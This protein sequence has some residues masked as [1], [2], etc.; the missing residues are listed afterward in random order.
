MLL[1]SPVTCQLCVGREFRVTGLSRTSVI[2]RMSELLEASYRSGDLGNQT[3]VL[4]ECVYILLSQQTRERVY[5]AVFASLKRRYPQWGDLLKAR[6]PAL[7]RLLTPAGFQRRRAEQLSQLIRRAAD[8]QRELAPSTIRDGNVNLEFLRGRSA[9]DAEKILASLPGIGPKSAR[10]VMLYALGHKVFPVDTN[11]HRMFARI[12]LVTLRGRKLDHDQLQRLVPPKLRMGLHV[13]LIHHARAVCQPQQ[14]RCSDCVLVSFCKTGQQRTRAGPRLAVDLF[15]GAGGL[16]SGF[17][18][19]GYEVVAAIEADRSAAQTYRLNNPGVAVIEACIGPH[20]T[21]DRLRRIIP[22][23]GNARFVLAGPPCQGYSAAGD[24]VAADPRNYLHRHVIRLASELGAHTVVLENVPGLRQYAGS[25]HQRRI[26][27]AFKIAGFSATQLILTA[28]DFGVPQHRQRVFYVATQGRRKG[29][30]MPEATHSAH[31]RNGELPPTPSLLSALRRLPQLSAGRIDAELY[32]QRG[33]L[34]LNMS[35]MNHS[36]RVVRKIASIGRGGGPISYRRLG[37]DEAHTLIAGHR[38]LP[39]HPTLDRAISV[40]EAAVIQGFP[41]SYA[42]LG[43]RATQPL[44]VA[45]AVP[46]PLAAAVARAI[47]IQSS[48]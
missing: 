26:S 46:P 16:A 28:C 3:D 20:T 31:G 12:G 39:V 27:R 14:P 42:F 7:Q 41:D 36:D 9:A 19:A 5:R 10:C 2:E 33:Q 25:A 13:N 47:R 8:L 23:I 21:I 11:I 30:V 15:S 22:A 44:Q 4:G 34:W 6:M 24:R 32:R 29:L 1:A 18:S 40:R 17:R 48:S 38:A 37:A 45:N 43:A 35:T